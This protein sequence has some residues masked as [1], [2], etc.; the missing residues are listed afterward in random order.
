MT[1]YNRI[2]NQKDLNRLSQEAQSN[3]RLRKNL[4]LHELNDPIQRFFNALEPGTYVQPHRHTAPPKR[5]TFIF[6]QGSFLVVLFDDTGEITDVIRFCKEDR[7]NIV[8]DLQP[9]VWH[10]LICEEPET[11]YFEIKDGPYEVTT[12]KDFAPWAPTPNSPP[13]QIYLT[14]LHQRAQIF[15]DNKLK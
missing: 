12:D 6:I 1:I 2:I 13:V 10:S 8:M 11:V 14:E 3:S 15:L 9:N 5:E 4:N 7:S